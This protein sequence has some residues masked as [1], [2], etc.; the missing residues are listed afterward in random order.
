MAVSWSVFETK[1]AIG[2]K[3]PIFHTPLVF[4]LTDLLVRIFAQNF[5]TNCPSPC[6]IGRCKILPKSSNL[7]LGCNN[8]TDRVGT[9]PHTV[10]FCANGWNITN[11]IFL[12]I[13]TFFS[14][15]RLQ[16]RPVDEFLR[17]ILKKTCL[18]WVIKFKFNAKPLMN[19]KTIKIWPKTGQFFSA[20][21]A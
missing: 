17:A 2:R 19:P 14:L 12:S 4:N 13:Y 20:E 3:T 16:V 5:N 15:T 21:Y 18:F 7:C 9:N 1:R 6:A 8:V 11:I 10:G